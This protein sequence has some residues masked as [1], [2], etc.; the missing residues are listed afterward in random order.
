MAWGSDNR[1]AKK[2]H[3]PTPWPQTRGDARRLITETFRTQGND[4]WR[5]RDIR[6]YLNNLGIR[7]QPI[8]RLDHEDLHKVLERMEATRM[9][10][11]EKPVTPA[12][13]AA[14]AEAFDRL[15]A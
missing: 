8:A 3:L 13:E 2:G 1:D 5:A 6:V 9:I 11:F 7:P 12:D 14:A 4:G 15:A 10:I